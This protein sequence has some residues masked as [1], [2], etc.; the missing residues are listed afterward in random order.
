MKPF[1][2]V[3][4]V[5]KTIDDDKKELQT[6]LSNSTIWKGLHYISLK[7]KICSWCLLLKTYKLVVNLLPNYSFIYTV[8]H[9]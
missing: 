8:T 5:A 3:Q 2:W 4:S 1:S 6:S 9:I 7:F